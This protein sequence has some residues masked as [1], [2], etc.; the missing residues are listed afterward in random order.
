MCV[1]ALMGDD[2]SRVAS[3]CPADVLSFFRSAYFFLFMFSFLQCFWPCPFFF[4]QG[5]MLTLKSYNLKVLLNL[6]GAT[7]STRS[8]NKR[9]SPLSAWLS[10]F[11]QHVG[12]HRSKMIMRTNFLLKLLHVLLRKAGK[13]GSSVEGNEEYMEFFCYR[14]D[15]STES[16]FISAGAVNLAKPLLNTYFCSLQWVEKVTAQM[17]PS[18]SPI[19]KFWHGSLF[20][21]S[22]VCMYDHGT[23]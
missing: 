21:T 12:Q 8:C 2:K 19:V 11:L 6:H 10:F 9:A 22:T 3:S 14:A 5:P 16:L 17:I 13:K 23:P 7:R 4:L 1:L 20:V 15:C 18:S